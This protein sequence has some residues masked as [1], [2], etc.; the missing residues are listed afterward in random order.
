MS[1]DA[2]IGQALR[3]GALR[4]EPDGSIWR[5]DGR[6]AEMVD[7]GYGRV[8]VWDCPLRLAMA[9]RVVW[10]AAHGPIPPGARVAHLNGKR[11]DN[12]PVN[13][14]LRHTKPRVPRSAD[15]AGGQPRDLG[16]PF[17]RGWP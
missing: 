3:N 8:R 4:V 7:D 11:F 16:A 10:I 13:L 5:P 2:L 6:R 14:T 9:H 17:S 1:V 15:G 12:R